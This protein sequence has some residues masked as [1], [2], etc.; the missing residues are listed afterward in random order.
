VTRQKPA[1]LRLEA[2]DER[3]LPSTTYYVGPGGNDG[4]LGTLADPF[5]TIKHALDL[6]RAGDTVDVRAGTYHEQVTFPR[7]G[8]AAA[9][10][11]S[12][13]AHAG[14]QPVLDGTGFHT[15][16]MVTVR[17]VSY[18]KIAGFEI[19]HFTGVNDGSG[20][21]VIGSGGNHIEIRNN[22]IHDIRGQ[23][24]MGVTV[25]GT[26]ALAITDLVIDGNEIFD[27][28]PAPSEALT[29][30]GNVARFQIT[31]NHVHDVNNIG[32]DVIGGEK[33]IH[34]TLG[35]R[36][37]VVRGNTVANAHAPG[38]GF[39]AG[40]YVDGGLNVLVEDNLSHHNDVGLAVGA[41]NRGWA[42]TGVTVR[43]NL[44]AENFKAGLMF[45][46]FAPTA[47][48]VRSSFFVHNTVYDND[49]L[50]RGFGQ[51]WIQYGGLNVVTNNVFVAAANNVL[52]DSQAGNVQNVLSNNLYFA[53]GG[54][55]AAAF[56]WNGVAYLGLT[57]FQTGTKADLGSM[58]A[59][60]RFV[61]GP[62]GDFHLLAD[63]PVIG[64][65][66]AL[67]GRTAWADFD[68]RQRW[69]WGRPDAGAFE[70]FGPG[71]PVGV[72]LTA[73]QKR[74]AEQLTSVFEND[75]PDLQYAYIA[76]LGDGRG[77][78]A[79]RAG[80]TSATADLLD[81]VERYTARVPG[82]PLAAY[83]PALRV[84]AKSHSGLLTGLTG[85]RFA[86]PAAAADPVFRAV[87]DQVVD[88]TYYH[89]A[90]VHATELGLTTPLAIAAVYD[91]IIQHGD[92]D[93]PDGLP[94]LLTRTA[95]RVGGTPATGVN[96]HT[97]LDTFLHVR[98]ED[99]AH[100]FDP[101]TRAEWA[102][103]VARVDVFLDIAAAGN[104]ALNGPITIDSDVYSPAIIP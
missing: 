93:D 35:A 15:G 1:R 4:A 62:G 50:G 44:I 13:T 73:D 92:G 27:A 102:G 3:A 77:V 40:I 32:I 61:D 18:V 89:P 101:T 57:A 38:D 70:F 99:L 22:L 100:A 29:V 21:R 78:T 25:Y 59:D 12:L 90:L 74:R 9:G 88:E 85:I 23:S 34:P 66:S 51:L 91:A 33:S 55:G 95:A 72:S 31:G 8:S 80:F 6:A 65:G 76:V 87:Q 20:V 68:G 24:A 83:L 79:G 10:Y 52:I 75:T 53:P 71:P 37:G 63:S 94:A 98:R 19:A 46:G 2:L 103:S 17:N 69:Q 5:A 67:A 41:E 86:W 45:G 64:L 84:L 48:R 82:N 49:T 104:Y 30:N 81:V 36:S 96:E 47:G 28:E 16:N 58:F 54:P 14:E 60:P 7:S 42:A 97:W 26:G 43:N 11:I 56:T 39:A